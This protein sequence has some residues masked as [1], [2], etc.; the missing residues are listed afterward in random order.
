MSQAD[1]FRAFLEGEKLQE[2]A[3]RTDGERL[4]SGGCLIAERRGG[5]LHIVENAVGAADPE[6]RA[7]LLEFVKW[8]ERRAQVLRSLLSAKEL[9]AA[10]QVRAAQGS[11][12]ATA[13]ACLREE[14]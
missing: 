8:R 9:L 13:P 7:L 3:L 4:F 6:H 1:V 10:T 12:S 5:K 2:A 14:A 11:G